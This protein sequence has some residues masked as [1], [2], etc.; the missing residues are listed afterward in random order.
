MELPKEEIFKLYCNVYKMLS[1][2]DVIPSESKQDKEPNGDFKKFSLLEQSETIT[3]VNTIPIEQDKEHSEKLQQCNSKIGDYKCHVAT[4]VKDS[5]GRT[6]SVDKCLKGAIENL[7]AHGIKTIASCCG[8]GVVQPSIK[9][10]LSEELI[11]MPEHSERDWTEDFP[12]ENGNYTNKC[13]NC[14][15]YFF[16]HKRR[17]LCK[18]CGDEQ[19]PDK[20]LKTEIIKQNGSYK[21][22]FSIGVQ[23]FTLDYEGDKVSCRW[24]IKALETALEHYAEQYHKSQVREIRFKGRPDPKKVNP[25]KA[26]KKTK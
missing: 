25:Y 3:S 26:R 8:H 11:G 15:E 16:G 6:V 21:I 4:D 9:V 20:G 23:H 10:E 1:G 5:K 7:N 14:G 13:S 12:H 24:I 22:K 18:L 19:H 17:P 2:K